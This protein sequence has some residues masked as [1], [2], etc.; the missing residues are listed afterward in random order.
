MKG[1]NTFALVIVGT[2]SLLLSLVKLG[3]AQEIITSP[4]ETNWGT[5][6]PF[7]KCPNGTFAQGF[8]LK[9]EPYR[10]PLI[11]D[12]AGNGVRLYCGDPLDT[13]TVTI[14]SSE[15]SWG[16][17]G[18]AFSCGPAGYLYGFQLRVEQNGI[19]DETATNNVRM[20]CTD[21]DPD[22]FLEGD[23]LGFGRWSEARKC[24]RTQGLC[25][26]ETQV[27]ADQ[28]LLRKTNAIEGLIKLD[29]FK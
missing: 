6:G 5:W 17:W 19:D 16:D 27:Q 12:T 8:A 11:D 15:G 7:V 2:V 13:D 22:D 20:F 9:T 18:S 26:I 29:F 14:T 25:G 23:G 4:P 10:G 28:G 3:V 21:Q 1:L 24:S